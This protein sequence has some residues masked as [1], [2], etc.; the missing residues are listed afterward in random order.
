MDFE[1][2]STRGEGGR[3]TEME[4]SKKFARKDWGTQTSVGELKWKWIGEVKKKFK[5]KPPKTFTNFHWQA[6]D[7]CY[8]A[9]E[10]RDA[11][12]LASEARDADPI[13][14]PLPL[15]VSMAKC[16]PE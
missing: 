9:S 12:Y 7:A 11:C 14:P 15:L 6:S 5:K 13:V 16:G 3:E 8:L 10:A 4:G 1:S 2:I